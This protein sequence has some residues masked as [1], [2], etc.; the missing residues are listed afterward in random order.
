MEEKLKRK[1]EKLEEKFRRKEEK[2]KRRLDQQKELPH[3][4][5]KLDLPQFKSTEWV[6]LIL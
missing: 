6:L 5:E 2:L 3:K 1:E 4:K